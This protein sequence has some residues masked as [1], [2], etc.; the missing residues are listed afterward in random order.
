MKLLK[1]IRKLMKLYLKYGNLEVFLPQAAEWP[2]GSSHDWLAVISYV[3]LSDD[4]KHI[5]IL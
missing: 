5:E 2:D 4:K 1:L 3:G